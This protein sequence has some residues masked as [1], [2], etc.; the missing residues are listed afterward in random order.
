L[1]DKAKKKLARW[2]CR[3]ISLAARVTLIKSALSSMFL[4][5]LSIFKV[6]KFVDIEMVKI[7]PEF[8]WVGKVTGGE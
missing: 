3:L 4:F 6:P 5:F 2:K 7:P 8:L 1:I